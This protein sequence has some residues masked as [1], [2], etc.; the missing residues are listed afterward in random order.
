MDE[1][2]DRVSRIRSRL[3]AALLLG[4]LAGAGLAGQAPPR[5]LTTL[6]ALRQFPS[7][8]HLQNVL[9]RGEFAD[10][11]TF[12]TLRAADQE[13]RVVFGDGVATRSGPV[14]VSGQ[15]VDIGRF[16][17][18]DPRA[19][20]FEDGRDELRWPR[21][22]EELLLN[23]TGVA[24][25]DSPR[26]VTVRSLALE[27]WRYEG[28]EISVVGQFRGRNI[29]GDLPAS[30]AKGRYDF[31][32]RS[33][34]G[35][36]WVTGL[37]PRGRDFE[38]NVT[39][40][41][42]TG[43]WVQIEGTILHERGLVMIEGAEISEAEPLADLEPA[44]PVRPSAP[45]QP[46][47]VVFSSPTFDEVEVGIDAPVRVQFSKG[48]DPDTIEGQIRVAYLGGGD[49]PILS[50]EHSY[51]PGTSALEIRFT[52]PLLRFRRVQVELLDGVRGFDGATFAAW[53][54]TFSV[55]G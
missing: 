42:D 6:D 41:V 9:L 7:Y 32:L 39:A 51:D 14:E 53:T 3:A 12:L 44:Q 8:F 21:P 54:L 19:A 55:G 46:L 27:P 31:V 37:R 1:Y 52:E 2:N 16:D 18:G 47:A 40:R 25:A 36:I 11:D 35:A 24:T 50:F 38:L 10:N 43:R 45:I 26:A 30:P 13:I 15:L 48:L 34:D 29:L 5:R 20:A 17:P 4:V 23:V 28:Q 33:G 22:G 49:L